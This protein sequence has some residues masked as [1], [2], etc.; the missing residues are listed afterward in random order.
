ME[1]I[2]INIDEAYKIKV[3]DI[4]DFEKSFFKDIYDNANNAIEE[5]Y[6]NTFNSD[7][8]NNNDQEINEYS[9]IIAFIGE[10]GT[11]KTS[12][13]VS[14]LESL[15][16]DKYLK[17]DIVDPSLFSGNESIFEVI[18]G[19]MFNQ[20][21]KKYQELSEN[22]DSKANE[23]LEEFQT[24]Y[25]NLRVL[26]N[27][28]KE[29]FNEDIDETI[30]ETLSRL[31]SGVTM[32][33]SFEKLVKK[34]IEY[35]NPKS[36]NAILVIPIDDLDMNIDYSTIM[37]EE[38]RK[39]LKINH[40]VILM[41]IKI[42]QML[43]LIEQTYI[44]NFETMIKHDKFTENPRE[45]AI[46][47]MEKL[48]PEGRKLRLPSIK[49]LPDEAGRTIE[50]Y[51]KDYG[52]NPTIKG[53]L[54][55]VVLGITYQ[56]TGLIFV[57]N[58]DGTHYLIPDNLRELHNYISF[59]YKLPEDAKDSGLGIEKFE[60]YFMESWINNNLPLN[61]KEFIN[62][63]YN[64]STNLKNKYIV[65]NIGNV[66]E[67]IIEINDTKLIKSIKEQEQDKNKGKRLN[68][69]EKHNELINII[70][71][72]NKSENISFGDVLLVLNTYNDYYDDSNIRKLIFAIKTMYSINFRKN[73]FINENIQHVR[74]LLGGKIF[75]QH[76]IKFLLSNRDYVKLSYN[77]LE[78]D[79]VNINEYI[80]KIKHYLNG[81]TY[82][83]PVNEFNIVEYL[84]LFILN[85]NE[86]DERAYRSD[87]NIYYD[88]NPRF[89]EDGKVGTLKYA[90]FNIL[91]FVFNLIDT[92]EY[93]RKI[94]KEL[95]DNEKCFDELIKKSIFKN[96]EYEEWLKNYKVIVPIYSLELLERI[97]KNV[98][99]KIKNKLKNNINN[100]WFKYIKV[101]MNSV[102]EAMEDLIESDREYYNY[103][104]QDIN[105]KEAFIKC[106][107]VKLIIDSN[108]MIGTQI[109][110]KNLKIG[111]IFN[112][113]KDAINTN[114]NDKLISEL[115]PE[116]DKFKRYSIDNRI[117]SIGFKGVLSRFIIF[118]QENAEDLSSSN[119]DRLI[120]L[121][122]ML[123][124]DSSQKILKSTSDEI[125]KIIDEE[126]G[127]LKNEK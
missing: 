18:I 63:F 32:K 53:N 11:G 29:L 19:V 84:N 45:M 23:L 7:S 26:K 52:I 40:V 55:N 73:I 107:I 115:R 28:R 126:I 48:L 67:S 114:I 116:R 71:R 57:K 125:V 101:F 99:S 87:D 122:V 91:A 119:I 59:I 38:I 24:V 13:M 90:Y 74:I 127:R 100:D 98:E 16:K 33:S 113:I 35:I 68:F 75:N 79:S 15:D 36:N 104:I 120:E 21:Q 22:D 76:E 93:L 64:V 8:D 83:L 43:S 20:F 109:S 44:Q 106:P 78:I 27:N 112:A 37:I 6:N 62:E 42:D 103:I 66:I 70:Q 118:C 86:I 31:A 92:D 46:R 2:K 108:T 50:I 47:Y 1:P 105:F 94:F 30:I 123:D 110:G 58:N 61:Y 34:Y 95:T 102:E 56:K 5:I 54:E 10:R 85:F 81:K 17:L 96:I 65:T 117:A 69:S 12:V 89:Q 60:K 77:K 9:N 25:R 111:M 51:K 41:A 80:M 49:V 3:E 121:R 72:E 88:V 4:K 97:F 14:F 124:A 39:Y 82:R